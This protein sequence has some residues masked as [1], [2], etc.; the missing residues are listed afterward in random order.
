MTVLEEKRNN[1]ITR[2]EEV[3]NTAKAE[4]RE[5]TSEEIT[6]INSIR[7]TVA[8]IDTT[9]EAEE[10]VRAMGNVKE[11]DEPMVEERAVDTKTLE[12]RA[13]ENYVRGAVINERAGELAKG[14][15]GAIIPTKVSEM[16]IKKVYEISPIL[17]RSLKFN[18]K[19]KLQIPYY[20]AD[21]SGINVAYANEFV[22]LTSSTGNFTSIELDGYLAGAL[23]KISRSLINN[24]EFDVVGFIID[25]MASAI[26]R[27]IEHEMLIGTTGKVTGLSTLTNGITAA[28]ATAITADEVIRLH[29][30]IVDRYHENAI[31]IMSSAT[32][33]ALR[34][35]KDG[36]NRY[37]LQDDISMPFG[38]SLLGKPVYVSDNMPEM[39]SGA[40]AIFYGDMTGLVT[41]FSENMEIQVLREHFATEHAD[42]V[43][44]WVEFDSKV[45]DQ[46]KI[47]A[48]TMA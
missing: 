17:E 23:T 33:T 1:L 24:V 10:H 21:G 34:L 28:A 14:Q 32:R 47:A 26:A 4:K 39:V 36:E 27:F 7:E 22:A 40:K 9:I 5:L 11:K 12:L 46:Q 13:F 19:G 8:N 18:V 44:G 29:D 3:L 41:K 25:E 43:I 30:S 15:N 20:G 2:A 6:E 42:G 37:L 16:I 48:I 45:V 38:S 31:W 35:L